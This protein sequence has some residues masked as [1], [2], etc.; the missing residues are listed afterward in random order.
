MR[1]MDD[2]DA[3]IDKITDRPA[4]AYRYFAMFSRFEFALK[5][6]PTFLKDNKGSAEANWEAFENS[7]KGKF[8]TVQDADFQTAVAFLK[9]HPPRKQVVAPG[10]IHADWKDVVQDRS[11]SD[12][13]FILRSIRRIRN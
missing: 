13:Q 6:L 12:E 8:S 7:L 10:G 11:A 9:T 2:L 5:E 4:L 3:F 1:S